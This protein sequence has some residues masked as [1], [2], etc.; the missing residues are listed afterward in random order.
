MQ[1]EQCGS[2]RSR[3]DGTLIREKVLGVEDIEA[4]PQPPEQL[5][6]LDMLTPGGRL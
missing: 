4:A 2:L 6:P 5:D 1:V 3:G